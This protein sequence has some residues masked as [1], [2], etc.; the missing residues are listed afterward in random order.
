[1]SKQ[2][3]IGGAVLTILVATLLTTLSILDILTFQDATR[4]LGKTA[5][6]IGVFVVALILMI[7]IVR[8]G[9]AE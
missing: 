8:I 4:T 9:K 6:V 5:S 3:L 1:M 7:S 2:V